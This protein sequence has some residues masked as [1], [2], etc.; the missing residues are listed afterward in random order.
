MPDNGMR[1]L[2]KQSRS[3]RDVA[4]IDW[5]R[6]VPS[7]GEVLVRT[8]AVGLCGS[9]VH[10]WKQ[11]IGY[12]WVAR[13]VVLG[14]EAVGVVIEVGSD[15]DPGWI[16]QRVVPISIDGCGECDVCATRRRHICPRRQVLGLSFHGAAADCF[17]VAAQRLVVVP[18]DLPVQ[19]LVL[20]EPLAIAMHAVSKLQDAAHGRASEIVVTGPGPIG[21][22]A[23]LLLDSFGHRVTLVGIARDQPVRLAAAAKL[24]LQTSQGEDLPLAPDMWL[25]ASGSGEALDRAVRQTAIGGAVVV[26]AVFA[27]IPTVDINVVTRHE[28]HLLGSYGASREDYERAAVILQRDPGRWDGLTTSFP[29]DQGVDALHA[30]EQG[31]VVKAILLP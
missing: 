28:L 2:V 30:V 15:V 25:E 4:V 29:L 8:E 19:A 6:P 24:G 27:R 23:A 12:E 9:D 1:A 3:P 10:A 22:M 21:L 20:T 11:D 13:S 31:S 7:A 5:R 17:T 18:D 26:P 16:G 14:H